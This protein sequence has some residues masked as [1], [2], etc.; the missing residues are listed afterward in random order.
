MKNIKIILIVL[1]FAN[2]LVAKE[3]TI[4]LKLQNIPKE[5]SISLFYKNNK[6]KKFELIKKKIV[7]DENINFSL[8]DTNKVGIYT[9]KS[10]VLNLDVIFDKED[11]S[12]TTTYLTAKKNIVVDKS[13]QNR[14]FYQLVNKYQNDESKRI[15]LTKA[16]NHYSINDKFYEIIL[17]E[18]NTIQL[19]TADELKKEI[20]DDKKL[21]NSYLVKLLKKKS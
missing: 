21:E 10:G 7:K 1:V 20:L 17:K 9:I 19:N 6:E 12:L 8:N 18:L 3:Y 15:L 5:Q 11:V 16:L 13:L 2:I 4:N 14:L